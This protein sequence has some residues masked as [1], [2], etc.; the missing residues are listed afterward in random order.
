MNIYIYI[1]IERER[2]RERESLKYQQSFY[3]NCWV[4]FPRG[5]SNK[6]EEP[7]FFVVVFFFFFGNIR[8]FTTAIKYRD[9]YFT[10]VRSAL[11]IT[12]MFNAGQRERGSNY[13]KISH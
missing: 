10:E 3:P 11:K 8:V 12:V 6:S 7:S 1:Y 2:K 5:G 9:K 4:L 13:V